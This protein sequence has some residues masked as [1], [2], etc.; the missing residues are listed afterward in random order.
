MTCTLGCRL[1]TAAVIAGAAAPLFA[2]E[3][4]YVTYHWFREYRVELTN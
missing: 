1:L 4:E 3:A 2:R